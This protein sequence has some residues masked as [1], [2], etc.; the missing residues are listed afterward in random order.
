M[1]IEIMV[2]E[3]LKGISGIPRVM[4]YGTNFL[5]ME[6]LGPSMTDIQ[7][8][9][10]YKPFSIRSLLLIAEQLITRIESLHS[11]GVFH[12]DIKKDNILMGLGP[13]SNVVYVID[14]G[15][16]MVDVTR[17]FQ[18]TLR[19]VDLMMAGHAIKSLYQ[20]AEKTEIVKY[21]D[22]CGH[23]KDED[24][25]DYKYLKELFKEAFHLAGFTGNIIFE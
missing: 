3:R 16:A 1:D 23:L 2:Y 7:Q 13:N 9:N 19:K 21:F 24:T 6:L 4:S 17:V 5:A 20:I 11:N 18:Q 10:S 8:N 14:F 12:R 22:Y 25:I 15:I